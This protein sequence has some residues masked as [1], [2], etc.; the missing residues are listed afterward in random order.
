MIDTF[1]TAAAV[2]AHYLA[3][4]VLAVGSLGGFGIGCVWLIERRTPCNPYAVFPCPCPSDGQN[5]R[6]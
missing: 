1:A 6:G 3:N 2:G 4:M 5:G